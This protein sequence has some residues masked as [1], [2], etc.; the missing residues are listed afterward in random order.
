MFN[1]PSCHR[2]VLISSIDQHLD[3]KCR[4]PTTTSSSSSDAPQQKQKPQNI[5]SIFAKPAKRKTSIESG[6]APIDLDQDTNDASSTSGPDA[7]A[8]RLKSEPGLSTLRHS[9]SFSAKQPPS[10]SSPKPPPAS[11][12]SESPQPPSRRDARRAALPL[13]ERVRPSSLDEFV[14]QKNVVG[15]NGILRRFIETDSCPSMILWGPPGV[16]KTTLARLITASTKSRFVELSAT[17]ASVAKCKDVFDEARNELRLTRRKTYLFLDEIHRFN[18]AQQ[19]IFLPYIERGDIMLIGATT[20]NP[21]FKLNSALLSRC[22]TFTLQKLSQDELYTIV[23]R[24]S[25]SLA[26]D[27]NLDLSSSPSGVVTE[28]ALRY[29]AGLAD[30][31]GR[32]AI[33]LFELVVASSLPNP[34][35]H[36]APPTP[37]EVDQLKKDLQRSHLL[38]D[39]K[40]DGH[41]D[42]ISAFHKSVR[43]SDPD[44][45][46]YYLARM[47]EAGEPPMYLARRMMRIASEDVGLADDSCLPFAVAT[48]AAVEKVGMPECDVILAHCAVKLA[49]AKKSVRVYRAYNVLK[50]R[51]AHDPVYRAASVPIHLRNAPT[52]LMKEIGYG[53][54]YK[55]NPNFADGKVKQ[56]YL[57]PEIQGTQ[58]LQELDLGVERDPDLEREEYF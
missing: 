54:E 32:S 24:I 11:S 25:V 47:L 42:T 31:D 56:E 1:C 39:S 30:G 4:T 33:N 49:T 53:K 8:K 46:L 2:A 9:S 21:S 35:A 48:A 36:T 29:L 7:P 34:S 58:F 10:Q 23:R 52:K 14:G 37:I 17:S 20:E 15:E 26:A 19:D 38:Y 18:R 51:F 50:D 22:R 41:Y 3:G 12:T 43:G 45:A 57:P 6:P 16:G 5:A 40:G 28:D 13:A 44:A 27:Y 55:Y